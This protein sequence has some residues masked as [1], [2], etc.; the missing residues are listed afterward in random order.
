MVGKEIW[1]ITARM[2]TYLK[3]GFDEC[4]RVLKPYG[5]LVFKW[6]ETDIKQKELFEVLDTIPIFGDKG[7]GNKTYW[8]VFMKES[9]YKCQKKNS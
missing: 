1:K 9:E 4:M 6:N 7:R 5:T 3:Q 8:F 2:E